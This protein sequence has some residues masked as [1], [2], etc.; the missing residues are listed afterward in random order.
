MGEEQQ[1][2][3][4]FYRKTASNVNVKGEILSS[5]NYHFSSLT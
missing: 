4:A 1:G 2:K 3:A 5:K